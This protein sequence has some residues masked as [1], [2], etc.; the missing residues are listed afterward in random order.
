MRILVRGLR[1]VG[2]PRR[3][4]AS[5]LQTRG[6]LA[7]VLAVALVG[8][9][10]LDRSVQRSELARVDEA[11]TVVGTRARGHTVGSRRD[12]G[13]GG[14]QRLAV[15]HYQDVRNLRLHSCAQCPGV[16][17]RQEHS[18]ARDRRRPIDGHVSPVDGDGCSLDDGRRSGCGDAGRLRRS[19]ASHGYPDHRSARRRL[20]RTPTRL[21]IRAGNPVGR[22]GFLFRPHSA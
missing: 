5:R 10:R 21:R 22:A 13:R 18:L 12:Q 17:F 15:G 19:F 6:H 7:T 8:T 3:G 11:R 16:S 9:A 2:V 20:G 14:P 1:T 4:G